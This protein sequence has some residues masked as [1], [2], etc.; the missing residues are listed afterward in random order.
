MGQTLKP[1]SDAAYA[2][3]RSN[4]M[5][6]SDIVPVII[7]VPL[8]R[9]IKPISIAEAFIARSAAMIAVSLGVKV[10]TPMARR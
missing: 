9:S 5:F 8:K 1:S 7:K 10:R 2:R 4:A 6:T 3:M